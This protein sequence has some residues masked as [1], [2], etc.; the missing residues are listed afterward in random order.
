MTEPQFKEQDL[1]GAQFERVSLRQ[2]SFHKVY[3]T[4]A[5]FRSVDFSGADIRGAY[6]VGAN[7]RNVELVDVRIAGEVR[8]VVIN[9]IEVGALIDAELNRRMPD[10]AKMRP[11]TAV[12]FREAWQI[13]ER[14]WEGTVAR[15]RTFS[16][17]ELHRSVDGEW[18]FI[19]TL[20]H[21][22]FASA[23]WVDRMILGDP[24]PW[25]PLELPWDEAPPW[26]GFTWDRDVR[27]SLD[28]ALALRT[29]RQA[30]AREV[31]AS[32]TD[33]QLAQK[34]T[35]TEPGHPNETDFP[36]KECLSVLLNEEWEHRL[37]AERDLT[38]I[39]LQRSSTGQ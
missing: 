31:M 4:G 3:M 15:A 24:S 18:S 39:E 6:L 21:V 28:E 37:Y 26:E 13:L 23:C 5:Q 34:V 35:R 30:T 38:A 27:I 19:Q 16:E 36:V 25:K 17:E 11:D 1:T 2:A 10:R 9:G 29:A 22:A 12:G 14:L 33:E 32:L 20:R 7:L 8:N